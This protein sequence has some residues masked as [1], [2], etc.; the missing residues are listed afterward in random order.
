MAVSM[1]SVQIKTNGVDV[2]HIESSP[3]S[4]F[5]TLDLVQDSVKSITLTTSGLDVDEWIH[6]LEVSDVGTVTQLK[7][8]K[9][10]FL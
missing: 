5:T 8:W 9:N 3:E 10:G 4:T 1:L 7:K 2:A 6:I